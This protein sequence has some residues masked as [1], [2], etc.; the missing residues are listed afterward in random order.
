MSILVVTGARCGDR[1]A[2]RGLRVLQA[3]EDDGEDF[4]EE[5]VR[6]AQTQ[7]EEREA[8]ATASALA[9]PPPPRRTIERYQ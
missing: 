2:R 1:H 8:H 3:F 4:G 7:Q 5:G 9:Q 6:A